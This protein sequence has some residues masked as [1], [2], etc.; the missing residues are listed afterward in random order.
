MR[1]PSVIV[2]PSL[3]GAAGARTGQTNRLNESANRLETQFRSP[4][5]EIGSAGANGM[6]VAGMTRREAPD[7]RETSYGG[8]F[9]TLANKTRAQHGALKMMKMTIAASQ[10]PGLLRDRHRAY[11]SRFARGALHVGAML[12]GAMLATSTAAFAQAD[13]GGGIQYSSTQT[14]GVTSSQIQ[15]IDLGVSN[16]TGFVSNTPIMTLLNNNS[17]VSI[18]FNAA[19]GVFSG[20]AGGVAAAPYLTN[21]SPMTGNYLAAQKN[22]AVTM[23]FSETQR[24]FQMTWGSVSAGNV[25]NF[26]NGNQLVNSFNGST[27]GDYGTTANVAFSFADVGYDRVVATSTTNSFEFGAI[28]VSTT[29]VDVAPIPLN[30]A[31]LGGLLS[32]LMMLGVNMK[33]LR[34]GKSGTWLA[35]RMVFASLAPRRLSAAAV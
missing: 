25:L 27:L 16:L 20:T 22:G 35:L 28:G 17:S 34:G 10:P 5:P 11:E 8:R 4:R 7:V 24:F 21:G 12:V 6:P 19:A 33:G 2:A 3:A 13:L 18:S 26:Y 15:T 32:F 31:S 23:A 30:A 29:A 9:P 1:L 14:T